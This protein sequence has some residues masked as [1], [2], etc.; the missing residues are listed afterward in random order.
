MDGIQTAQLLGNLLDVNYF[1]RRRVLSAVARMEFKQLT[2]GI[3]YI[4]I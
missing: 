1:R 3:L 2:D 4:N